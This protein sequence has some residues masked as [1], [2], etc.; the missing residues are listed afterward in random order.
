MRA[1]MVLAGIALAAGPAAKAQCNV[2]GAV[3]GVEG[4]ASSARLTRN[5]RFFPVGRGQTIC[6]GD[7][8]QA[9]P[10]TRIRYSTVDGRF[11]QV[12]GGTRNFVETEAQADSALDADSPPH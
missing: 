12:R 2:K 7:A 11:E 6:A 1:L 10:N 8:L 5:G 4:D 3:D 9:G